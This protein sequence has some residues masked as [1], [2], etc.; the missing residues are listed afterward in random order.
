MAYIKTKLFE[1]LFSIIRQELCTWIFCS[2]EEIGATLIGME[3]LC[4]YMEVNEPRWKLLQLMSLIKQK[5]WLLQ[6]D[7]SVLSRIYHIHVV[8]T[9]F[10]QE[11]EEREDQ[12]S[13]TDPPPISCSTGPC[14]AQFLCRCNRKLGIL[15]PWLCIAKRVL[16][17]N[18][19]TNWIE[20]NQFFCWWK[21]EIKSL[22]STQKG[23][24]EDPGPLNVKKLCGTGTTERRKNGKI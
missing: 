15:F 18:M 22:L 16:H 10:E 4:I 5:N 24:A 13:K 23:Y 20:S 8:F 17:T 12:E 19:C 11:E 2:T 3:A 7:R 21:K 14:W 9:F 6:T 1:Q